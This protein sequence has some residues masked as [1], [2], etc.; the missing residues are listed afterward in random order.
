[1]GLRDEMDLLKHKVNKINSSKI[2][3]NFIR[4]K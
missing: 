3:I 2:D 4:D 1:M